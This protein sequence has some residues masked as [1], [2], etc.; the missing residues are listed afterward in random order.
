MKSL[1]LNEIRSS[2]HTGELGSIESSRRGSG[3]VEDEMRGFRTGFLMLLGWA[4]VGLAQVST[5]AAGAGT[6]G[7]AELAAAQTWVG[8]GAVCAGI[9]W[10]Q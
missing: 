9:L 10:G 3:A 7:D 2:A 6:A 4:C 5:G 8:A 1:I